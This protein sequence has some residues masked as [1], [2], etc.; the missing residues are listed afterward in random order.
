[1]EEVQM[2][3]KYDM[4]GQKLRAAQIEMDKARAEYEKKRHDV[5]VKL[6]LLDEN[7]IK[8]M[9]QQLVLLHSATGMVLAWSRLH[10]ILTC[11][12]DG[13][14]YHIDKQRRY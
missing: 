7:R 4:S 9:R 13:F 5:S 10:R 14:A 6:E 12:F 3:P 8:V 11:Q 2:T 1:M